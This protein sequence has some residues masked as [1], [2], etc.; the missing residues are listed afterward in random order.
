ME[1]VSK[2]R[3]FKCYMCIPFFFISENI[4]SFIHMKR[5]N[6]NMYKEKESVFSSCYLHKRENKTSLCGKR[7]ST[8]INTHKY[9]RRNAIL[10]YFRTILYD[11]IGFFIKRGFMLQQAISQKSSLQQIIP[12]VTMAVSMMLT[13]MFW[14]LISKYYEKIRFNKQYNSLLNDY[15]R[16]LKVKNNEVYKYIQKNNVMKEIK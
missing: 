4:D 12:S 15:R 8:R 14:P 11:G 13:T 9:E 2:Y 3:E 7:N 16:Y 6:I 1:I 5:R 10:V